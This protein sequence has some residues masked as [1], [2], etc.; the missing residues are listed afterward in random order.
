MVFSFFRRK[1]KPADKEVVQEVPVK[2]EIPVHKEEPSS[3]IEKDLPA[4]PTDPPTDK[5]EIPQDPAPVFVPEKDQGKELEKESA[6]FFPGCICC[7]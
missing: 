3:Q 6:L 5:T 2:E 1:K 4:P 7:S